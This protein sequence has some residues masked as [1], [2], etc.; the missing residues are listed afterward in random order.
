MKIKLKEIHCIASW[1][2]DIQHLNN[3][4]EEYE[5]EDVCGICR[6]SYNGTCPDCKYPGETCP[7]VVGQCQHNF[8]VHCIYQW[9]NTNTS[10]GLCPM[11]RQLFSLELN[12]K[13]N[14]PHIDKFRNILI[15]SQPDLGINGPNSDDLSGISMD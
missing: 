6:A 3:E 12:S 10:K 11:C 13:I 14:E 9:L 15:E 2:W 4:I 8:H 1:T 7:L 5:D